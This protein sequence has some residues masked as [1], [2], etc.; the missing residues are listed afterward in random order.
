MDHELE[1]HYKRIGEKGAVLLFI[2]KREGSCFSRVQADYAQTRR[3][4]SYRCVSLFR[5]NTNR[6]HF[7]EGPVKVIHLHPGSFIFHVR[8]LMGGWAKGLVGGR[9]CMKWMREGRVKRGKGRE[10]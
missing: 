4:R 8:F 6:R 7:I 5:L 10:E 9:G 2:V 3:H 1:S